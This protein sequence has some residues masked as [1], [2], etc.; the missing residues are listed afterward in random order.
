[1]QASIAGKKKYRNPQ[2]GAV[3]IRSKRSIFKETWVENKSVND[4]HSEKAILTKHLVVWLHNH[5][6]KFS[7]RSSRSYLHYFSSPVFAKEMNNTRAYN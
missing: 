3:P 5:K 6:F 1:M 4:I 7:Y 2:L